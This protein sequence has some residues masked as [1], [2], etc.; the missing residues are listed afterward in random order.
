MVT[1]NFC[2]LLCEK[3]P[4]VSVKCQKYVGGVSNSSVILN[5]ILQQQQQSIIEFQWM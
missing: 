5:K 1:L 4:Q 2:L 3:C